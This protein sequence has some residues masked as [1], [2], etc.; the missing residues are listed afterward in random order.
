MNN[1]EPGSHYRKVWVPVVL[2]FFLFVCCISPAGADDSATALG[3]I[4]GKSNIA[5]LAFANAGTGAYYFKFD[6]TSGGGLNALH[7]ASS[8]SSV[9]NYGDVTTTTGQSGTFYITD[10]GGRGYQDEAILLVAVKGNIPSDFSIH[11]TS[12]GYS[13]TP[14]GAK[15]TPPSLSQVTYRSGAVDQTFTRSDFVYGSQTWKPAG[16]NAPS[17]YPLYYGQDTSDTTNT[18]KLM[19][20]DLRAG[21]LG[22][23]GDI[24]TSALTD[25]GAIKVDYTIENLD[26]VAAFNTYAWNENTTQGKGISWANRLVGT[27]SSGYT[28]L[29]SGYKDRA[30]EF[31]TVE[32][33]APVYHAPDTDFKADVTSGAAPLTVQFTDTTVQ[34]VKTWAWDFGDGSTSTEKSPQHVYVKEGT[35]TVALSTA[36]TQGLSTT[37]TQ[38]GMITVTDS[39]GGN[40]AGTSSGGSSGGSSDDS[41]STGY[42]DTHTGITYRVNFTANATSGVA[43][44]PIQFNDFSEIPNSTS[45]AWDF[46]GDGQPE[47]TLKNPSYIF[48]TAGNYSVNL[49]Q[50]TSD[51]KVYFLLRSQYIRVLDMPSLDSD[52]GWISSD[53]PKNETNSSQADPE[54]TVAPTPKS[55]ATD[56]GGSS[57]LGTKVAEVLFDSMVVVGVIGGGL[58]L[59]RKM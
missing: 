26:T 30:S 52:E 11:I 10:T 15:D 7:I 13:W 16:N 53:L 57:P 12:S 44:F 24:D 35:Y 18:F 36:N 43:P 28:V 23:N 1:H 2:V 41:G 39:T 33:S 14:T 25:K 56:T 22:A 38:T 21:P 5:S 58:F 51:G 54:Q 40:A 37:K 47:S 59:W 48:R 50:T 4:P 9:T 46:T 42:T 55:T 45:W 29:G 20:V 31:P 32:G 49:T 8:S 27:G 3:I 17:D 34:S 19:F 6:Q